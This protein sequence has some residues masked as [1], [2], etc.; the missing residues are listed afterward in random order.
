MVVVDV[1]AVLVDV[2]AEGGAD[3]EQVAGERDTD[4][5]QSRSVEQDIER[6]LQIW[7]QGTEP[8][9]VGDGQVTGTAH[10]QELGHPLKPQ[11][12]ASTGLKGPVITSASP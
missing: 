7:R 3:A 2:G 1:D 10:R 11:T 5:Y 6:Q 9:Q 4:R 12:K 8:E